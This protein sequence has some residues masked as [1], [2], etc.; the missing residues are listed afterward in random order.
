MKYTSAAANKRIKK[1]TEEKELYV[2]KE[3]K[4]ASYVAA[5]DET[6]LVPE[7]DYVQNAAEIE[8][9][10]AE[11]V[12]LKHA[13]NLH[14]ALAE[15]DVDGEKMSVD[16]ILIRMAQLNRRIYRLDEMR[17]ALPKQRV[18][19]TLVRGA[20]PEYRYANY[21]IDVV[22]A[23]Y[24]RMSETVMKMQLALDKYNQTYEFEVE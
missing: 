5:V 11:I 22:R 8:K 19:N 13:I 9:I 17:K 23:D 7:F 20:K 21:D 6:P 3:E 1:L 12:R 15:I 2:D 16:Q 24:E 10:D 18:D 14:N 4:S